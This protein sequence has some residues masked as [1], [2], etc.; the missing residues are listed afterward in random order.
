M[1]DK[2]IEVFAHQKRADNAEEAGSKQQTGNNIFVQGFAKGTTEQQLTNMFKAYGEISSAQIHKN[3][4]SDLL[5][6]SAY[7]C[8]K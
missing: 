7:V 4:A 8:F 6:N 2:K 5:S 1:A 3:D